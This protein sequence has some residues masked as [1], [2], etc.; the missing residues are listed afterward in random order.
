M[1]HLDK[2]WINVVILSLRHWASLS[3]NK[4]VGG[5][6]FRACARWLETQSK[7]WILSWL[8]AILYSVLHCHLKTGMIY[9]V[10]RQDQQPPLTE[11]RH[12]WSPSP[13]SVYQVQLLTCMIWAADQL[14]MQN[15][16]Y[17]NLRL[18]KCAINQ[19]ADVINSNAITYFYIKLSSL[20]NFNA[21]TVYSLSNWRT[22]KGNA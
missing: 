4:T 7:G 9:D 15:S 19:P 14:Q 5:A 8:T 20:E 10:S 17:S 16:Q 2:C 21:V 22:M 18:I 11:E 13:T 1:L 3:V 6:G 12:N